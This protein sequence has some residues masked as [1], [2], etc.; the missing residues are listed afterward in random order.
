[1]RS[2]DGLGEG[3]GG[4]GEGGCSA[5]VLRPQV[6]QSE[7]GGGPEHSPAFKIFGL[8]S[9]ILKV[10]CL[11]FQYSRSDFEIFGLRSDILNISMFGI[12]IFEI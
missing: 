3:E 4:G 1:M 2:N 9:D 12:S 11:V 10:Q 6:S 7:A 5:L 8:R